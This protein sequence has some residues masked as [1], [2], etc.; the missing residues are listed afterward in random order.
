M[1]VE[2]QM[3]FQKL[4][5]FELFFFKF[6]CFFVSNNQIGPEQSQKNKNFFSH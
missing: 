4:D 2:L 3:K 5:I 1:A 6:S